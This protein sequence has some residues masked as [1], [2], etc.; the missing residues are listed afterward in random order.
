MVLP[1]RA[2]VP[3]EPPAVV[4]VLCVE[5]PWID[6]RSVCAAARLALVLHQHAAARAIAHVVAKLVALVA[7][8]VAQPAVAA[9]ATATAVVLPVAASTTRAV[10]AIAVTPTTAAAAA[11]AAAV[12]HARALALVPRLVVIVVVVAVVVVLPAPVT[13]AAAAAAALLLVAL[14]MVPAPARAATAAAVA[15]VRAVAAEVR[16]RGGDVSQLVAAETLL[17]V[18]DARVGALEVLGR[19]RVKPLEL[20]LRDVVRRRAAVDAAAYKCHGAAGVG[21]QRGGE[22][23]RGHLEGARAHC[24]RAARVGRALAGVGVRGDRRRSRRSG[25]VVVAVGVHV[26][27]GLGEVAVLVPAAAAAAARAQPGAGDRE[28]LH[29]DRGRDGGPGAEGGGVAGFGLGA[30]A[31]RDAR[32]ELQ[33]GQTRAAG[34]V[35]AAA[36][37]QAAR[38]GGG[39][40]G[41]GGLGLH[42]V[43]DQRQ[44]LRRARRRFERLALRRL[45][46]A[47]V[48]VA[49]SVGRQQQ[50]LREARRQPLEAAT[51][52]R[53]D[54]GVP[55]AHSRRRFSDCGVRRGE[56]LAVRSC[57]RSAGRVF[58]ALAV[59]ARLIVTVVVLVLGGDGAV[60]RVVNVGRHRGTH[61]RESLGHTAVAVARQVPVLVTHHAAQTGNHGVDGAGAAAGARDNVQQCR[62]RVRHLSTAPVATNCSRT[63]TVVDVRACVGVAAA[64]VAQGGASGGVRGRVDGDARLGGLRREQ[65]RA[66]VLQVQRRPAAAARSRASA[67]LEHAADAA[68]EHG[69]S[70]LRR[71]REHVDGLD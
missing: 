62:D 23:E 28:M 25:V 57:G 13:A 66:H 41:G 24:D 34:A 54:L 33:R 59:I 48:R 47:H 7:L 26:G 68:G 12:V 60:D 44:R 1:A 2:P 9:R 42:S 45:L 38:G 10:P 22:Q 11:A 55:H 53:R 61:D 67:G 29:C 35:A 17:L 14:H 49:V 51:L 5:L 56:G 64:V 43:R 18:S 3:L 58:L 65:P 71:G 50:R 16:A 37:R 31:A 27:V 6:P 70:Q 63:R 40:D 4:G 52:T 15:V 20:A 36:L 8:N 19:E 46:R 39:G 69:Q 30:V 21:L 32:G